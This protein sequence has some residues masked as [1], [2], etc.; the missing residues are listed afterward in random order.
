MMNKNA[1]TLIVGLGPTGLSCLRYLVSQ[2][3]RVAVTDSRRDPPALAE[4]RREFPTVEIAIGGFSPAL[5]EAASEVVLSPGVALTEPLVVQAKARGIQPIGDIELFAR[6]ARA[7]VVAITGSNG[8]STVTTL[9]GLMAEKAGLKVKVGGNLG[10]PALALLEISEPD[11]YVLELSSFQLDTS[12]SLKTAAAVVLNV[13]EDHMDR[14]ATFAEYLKSKQRIYDRCQQPVVNADEPAI[15]KGLSFEAKPLSFTV[16]TAL[17]TEPDDSVFSVRSEDSES[18]LCRG[19]QK[20]IAVHDMKLKGRHH[21]QNA[22]AALALG[23]ALKLPIAAMAEVLK[24][25]TGLAHRCQWVARVGGADWFNDSKGTNVG[26]S[27]AAILSLGENTK[28]QKIILLAGGQG[29]NADFSVLNEA[30]KQ[31]VKQ[32]IVFGQDAPLLAQAWQ[33][34]VAIKRVESLQAAVAEAARS[35]ESEDIVLLSPAC[36]SLDMFKN[37]EDRGDQFV[38]AVREL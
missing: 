37:F 8:K 34:I 9:L 24:N 22:L 16:D 13:S 30:L 17:L 15:W 4:A 26:A 11:L 7:P 21:L 23:S 36:A 32:V 3:C 6:A 28:T 10:T 31:H 27:L 2:G 25:F 1:L 20:R 35:V 18:Y 14:Y 29:K 5:F 33:D 38:K 19:T 12:Y